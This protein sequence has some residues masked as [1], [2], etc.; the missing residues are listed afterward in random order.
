MPSA[1]TII[2][3]NKS[4]FPVVRPRRDRAHFPSCWSLKENFDMLMSTIKLAGFAIVSSA[5]LIGSATAA[6]MTGAQIKELVSGKSVY[7]ENTATSSGGAGQG[8]IYYAVDG[9]SLF[10]TAKG[11]VM[12][13]TW[14]VKE[15]TLCNDWKEMPNNPCSRYD[16]VGEVIT[17]INVATGQLRGKIV[18]T[19]AGNAEKIGS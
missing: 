10:K 12:R 18:K 4:V 3:K 9:S 14:S 11:D 5:F 1:G 7:L 19:A 15:N 2:S 6:D 17:V 13:G 8:V 16:K